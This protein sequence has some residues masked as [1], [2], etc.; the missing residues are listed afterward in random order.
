MPTF[1]FLRAEHK[2]TVLKVPCA[3]LNREVTGRAADASHSTEEHRACLECTTLGRKC[4]I[5]LIDETYFHT[6]VLSQNDY[7]G[8]I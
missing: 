4:A 8:I 1:L 5:E 6:E 7:Y 3:A 2:V